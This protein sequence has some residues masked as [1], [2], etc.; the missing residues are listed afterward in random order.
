MLEVV[1][2][3]CFLVLWRGDQVAGVGC[4]SF[5]SVQWVYE[6]AIGGFSLGSWR[7][8]KENNE[9]GVLVRPG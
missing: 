9:Q 5:L 2:E 7:R 6:Q 1:Q 8:V 3:L 4:I